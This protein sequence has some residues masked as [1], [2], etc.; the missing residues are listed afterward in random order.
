MPKISVIIPVYNCEKYLEDCL[1]SVILQ[2]YEN[3]EIICIDDGSKDRSLDIL[4]EYK[5]KDQ[6]IIVISQEN[7]GQSCARN[8]GM[9]LA[10]G[11]YISFVD[12]DDAVSLALYEK[13]C[14]ALSSVNEDV[15]IYMFNACT[16]NKNQDIDNIEIDC[17]FNIKEWLN[18]KDEKTIHTF[19][20]C[21]NPFSGNMS[22][23]NKIYK[24]E[25]LKRNNITFP[26]NL[27]FEDQYFYIKTFL[28]AQKIVI[29]SE[30]LYKYRAGNASSTM[31]TL[32]GNVF[33]IFEIMKLIEDEINEKGV[34]EDYK[35]AFLQHRYQQFSYLFF[36]T[37]FL[38][39]RNFYNKCRQILKKA[40]DNG[41]D[42]EICTKLAGYKIYRDI[43]DLDWIRFYL[44][45]RNNTK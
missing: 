39:K 25:F 5:E 26:E 4:K 27:I 32:S 43:L 14:D 10:K 8:K 1:K 17:F 34:S 41:F 29:N 44:K 37:K 7:S 19:D 36:R 31:S 35:Y 2:T 38:L 45:H 40:R 13:F 42:E 21:T 20:D 11:E 18:H 23:V 3:L 33:D 12:A 16:Y 24:K 22:A 28:C 15:D 6:R 30:S 9:A